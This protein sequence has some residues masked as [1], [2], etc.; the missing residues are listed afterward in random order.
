[1]RKPEFFFDRLPERD[2]ALIGNQQ[3]SR[4]SKREKIA[5]PE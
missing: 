1:M 3:Y 2:F 5:P 4:V